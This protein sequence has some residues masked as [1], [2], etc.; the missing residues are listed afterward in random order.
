MIIGY[1]PLIPLGGI[2][3][4]QL[5]NETRDRQQA[6]LDNT[7]QVSREVAYFEENIQ[8]ID[9]A[10]ELVADRTLLSVALGAFGLQDDIDNR[11]FIQRV[12][13]DGTL[14][15]DS[16]AN[17][18]SDNRYLELSRAFG[19]GDFPVP[20][21]KT[22]FFA[23][24]V[25][26]AYK[27]RSFEVAVGEVNTDFRL[28]L[29]LERDL[30]AL[31]E[32]DI[33]ENAKWLTIMGT[34]PLRTV[35]ETAFGLPASF[36]AIDLDQ[37]LETFKEMA[38]RRFGSESVSQFADPEARE[39]LVRNFLAQSQIQSFQQSYTPGQAALTLLSGGLF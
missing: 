21:N 6:I 34:T 37:Q 28:A 1:T 4:F 23:A 12:L 13:E 22:S 35:F 38:D 33:S 3:G 31:A 2:A 26:T 9:T 17:R 24:E 18:L 11:F 16:L 32:R 20:R 5:L 30:P 10:E 19:F 15:S 29:E 36:G 27:E 7:P 39:E 25:T 14:K 8:K